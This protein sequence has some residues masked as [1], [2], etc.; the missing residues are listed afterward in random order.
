MQKWFSQ[1]LPCKVEHWPCTRV[2]HGAK[3]RNM[4]Q[5]GPDFCTIN[6][7]MSA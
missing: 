3:L 4:C 7:K 1:V 2:E 6:L 5:T